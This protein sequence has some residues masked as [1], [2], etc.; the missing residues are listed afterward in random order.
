M[1]YC[2]H[3]V[4]RLREKAGEEMNQL[5]LAGAVALLCP[6]KKYRT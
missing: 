5:K 1:I 6:S 3:I 4:H 2:W